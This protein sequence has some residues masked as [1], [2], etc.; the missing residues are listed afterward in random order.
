MLSFRT[1]WKS[2]CKRAGVEM[3]PYDIRHIA[4]SEM[5]ARGTDLAA[6]AAQL[7]HCSVAI[8]GS[9]HA[10]AAARGQSLAARVMPALD[11]GKEDLGSG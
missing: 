10:H 5:L 7:G 8:T 3:R 6:V 4:A 1:A 2:A 9:V 11:E